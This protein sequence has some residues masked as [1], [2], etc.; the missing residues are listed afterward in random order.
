MQIDD[1]KSI[2]STFA[3]PATELLFEKTRLVI[4]VNGDLLD[5]NLTAK[6]GDI[7]VDE[8]S[9]P[10]P[11]SNWILTRLARLPLLAT[12]LKETVGY[13]KFFITPAA[14]LL[15]SLE[16]RPDEIATETLDALHTTQETIDRRSPLETTILYITSDAGEGK[17]SLI[18]QLAHAQATRFVENQTDWLLVP[19]PLGGRH[20]LRFDDITVGALQNRYRFPFL[21]YN[22]FLA[23][24][25][26]GVIVPAFDG[27]EE[28]FVENSSG[29][30]LSAMGLLVGAL[31][32]KGA[33][34]IATRKAYFEFEN[35]KT[36]E[37]LYD[38]IKGYSVGFAKLDIHRWSKGQ[39]LAYAKKRSL[40]NPERV[41]EYASERLTPEHSLLTRAV[42]VRRLLDIAN[43]APSMDGFLQQIHDSGPDFFSTFVRSIIEREATEKWIDRS[44]DVA[45]Q[46]LSADEHCELL[47]LAA[48]AMWESH[49]DYLKR[50][51]LYFVADYFSETKGKSV[52]QAKQIRERI[53][54]HALLI[55]STNANQAVEFDHEEFRLFFLGEGIAEQALPLNERAKADVLNALRRGPLPKHAQHA[56]VRAIKRNT[57]A[58]RIQ[59]AKFL[60]GIGVLDGQTSYT[61]EN[62]SALLIRLLTEIDSQGLEVMGLMFGHNSLRGRHLTNI[63]FVNCYFYPTS[64]EM[65]HL[66]MC[67]FTKTQFGQLRIF[68]NTTFSEVELDDCHIDAL[69]FTEQEMDVWEPSGVNQ[70]LEKLGVQIMQK[71]STPPQDPQSMDPELR[72]IERLLRYFMRSTTISESVMLMKIGNTARQFIDDKVPDLLERGIFLE[73]ENYGNNAVRRFRLGMS[74]QK[75]SSAITTARGSYSKFLEMC[76]RQ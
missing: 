27:F 21:Y 49:V 69:H 59:V 76:S 42:L 35:L 29:E 40:A 60:L 15:P 48:L 71:L 47:S 31:D 32:S 45:S 46:L 53:L 54:G 12:R 51:H 9:G 56:C 43:E 74:M 30:A 25:K 14:K 50:E 52:S 7:Y 34:L 3:D 2:V 19:I 16:V 17:T 73:I 10:Q 39:F 8:G 5:V 67:K 64:L 13:N 55:P 68:K 58:E 33:V 11:A 61:Q 72:T 28:M 65:T 1:F 38:T 63:H 4:S 57:K 44:G 26:M 23:L 41:Y 36:Q 37:K 18:N 70:Q 75:I 20:F 66:E 6:R 62:C 22:S 24:V